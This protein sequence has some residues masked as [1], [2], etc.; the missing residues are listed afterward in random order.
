MAVQRCRFPNEASG[1]ASSQALS[2]R[3]QIGM[4]SSP[5][6]FRWISAFGSRSATSE[7]RAKLPKRMDS[8]QAQRPFG[9][10]RHPGDAAADLVAGA[11]DEQAA[12]RRAGPAPAARWPATSAS[13]YCRSTLKARTSTGRPGTGSSKPPSWKLSPG[14]SS[15]LACR[16]RSG[17]I[18]IPTTRTSGADG[19]EALEEFDG[20]GRGGAVAEVDDERIGPRRASARP[21]AR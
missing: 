21:A 20:G 14:R 11:V 12:R 17:S 8:A 3:L 10:E 1:A 6:T 5:G 2:M 7:G 18:S 9:V 13:S 15:A 19:G 16:T 4:D